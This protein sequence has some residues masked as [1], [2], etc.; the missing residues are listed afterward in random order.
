MRKKG[1]HHVVVFL[2]I[3][4]LLLCPFPALAS[5]PSTPVLSAVPISTSQIVLSWSNVSNALYY[6][7]YRKISSSENYSLINTFTAS[8]ARIYTD[9]GLSAG[10]TYTYRIIA[11]NNEGSST[12]AIVSATTDYNNFTSSIT[13]SAAAAG[14][15]QISLSWGAISNVNYYTVYRSATYSGTYSSIATTVST[16]YTDSSLSLNTTYY[17]K[18]EAVTVSGSVYNSNIAYATT[19]TSIASAS[20]LAGDNRYDTAVKISQS[21]WNSS[22]YAVIVCGENY[23]DALCSAPLAAKYNAPI[24]LVTKTA[25]P[26]QT[27]SELSR[28][29]VRNVF[30][31]GGT[32]VIYT[33]VEL[34]IS[35]MGIQV[36]RL[37]GSDRYAT[38]LRVA[39][40]LGTTGQA[41]IANGDN[42]A[43]ALSVAP[44][45]AYRNMP[46][47][48]TPKDSLP[49]GIKQYLT[50]FY[51]TYVIGGTGV[52]SNTVYNQLP[53]PERLSGSDRY[54][55]NINI[56]KAFAG[57]LDFSK[58]YVATGQSFPD[59]L[60]GAALAARTGSPMLLVSNPPAAS[61]VNYLQDKIG[62][63]NSFVVFGGTGVV[64]QSVVTTLTD[65]SSAA[66]V[67]YTP[68]NLMASTLSGN[69]VY[70]TWS[71]SSGASFYEIYRATSYNGTYS[72]L[73]FVSSPGYTDKNLTA[74]TTYY[75]KV[76]AVNSSGSSA[77][78][79]VAS[80]SPDGYPAPPTNFTAS[81]SGINR[82]YLSWS[83]SSLANSYNIYRATS[84]NGS[85]S[86]LTSTY[87]TYYYDTGVSPN[88]TYYYKVAAVNSKG[89]SGYSDI[90]SASAPYTI[91]STPTGFYAYASGPTSIHLNWDPSS[92]ASSY[93]I[94]RTD[95]LGQVTSILDNTVSTSYTD[96]GVSP[97]STYYYR[98]RAHNSAGYSGYSTMAY[99]TT[100][101]VTLAKPTNLSATIAG[102]NQINLYWNAVTYADYYEI[103]RGTSASS[104]P[105]YTAAGGLTYSDSSSLVNGTTYY[106]QIR[107]KTNAGNSSPLSDVISIE[108][109]P[110]QSGSPAFTAGIPATY[111]TQLTVGA[112]TLGVK[113]NLTY[114][115][116]RSDNMTYDEGA[117][118]QV[119]T[120]GTTYTPGEDDIGKYLIVVV[121]TPNATG[122][123][124]VVTGAVA[125]APGPSAPTE[126]ITGTFPATAD[127]INLAGLAPNATGLEAAVA[128][129]GTNYASYADLTVDGAGN[130]TITG[131]TGVTETT[132]VRIRVKETATTLAGAAKEITVTAA[133]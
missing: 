11:R 68:T 104:I 48:L 45:A 72:Y 59:A 129:D 94:Y 101:S 98:I 106:Y 86:L 79:A 115:W 132:K 26:S 102:P 77:Y 74:G 5:V 78:S 81:A 66:G 118:T 14:S 20:R 133:P 89:F 70:L 53:S 34:A 113:S 15:S 39:Q 117:D 69:Q 54:E 21:G 25:L 38:S 49:A 73:A 46:I 88:T 107:A 22:N 50:N 122:T 103:Y 10:T 8:S 23:P 126:A 57:Y 62:S 27:R 116:Y 92:G 36:T 61:T 123:G 3:F 108:F 63:I 18:V 109:I 100:S 16:A 82:I 90:V 80:T 130:A 30:L 131:L 121:T 33:S 125:K 56:I 85:Y 12:S 96:N 83:A 75:Y 17:Y 31:I 105:Y 127:Q 124:I 32:G 19:G 43:D 91:P 6:D 41:F 58:C 111:G 119:G 47:L 64:P 76:R 84:Y 71:A 65:P 37:A 112:G 1:F 29:G 7:L 44:I 60:S 55:T 52:I 35:N 114:K 97:G 42:F 28:L 95:A 2:C 120:T 110:P 4:L 40:A 93:Y 13:L 67:P 128:I 51:N 9:S 87:E 24:L 99:A